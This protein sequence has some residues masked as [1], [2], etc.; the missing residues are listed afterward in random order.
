[1]IGADGSYRLPVPAGTY[2]V[3]AEW[4]GNLRSPRQVV[5]VADGQEVK[6]VNLALLQGQEVSGT[7]REG[8]RPM[9]AVPVAATA[10]DG[11]KTAT[12]TLPAGTYT[13]VLTNGV[14]TLSA[15]GVARQVTVADGPVDGAD[16][17]S[18]A[19]SGAKPAAGTIL[20]LAG[21][22]MSGYGG[23]GGPAL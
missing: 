20:T 18:T 7:V 12:Q 8:E 16:F 6:G 3:F 2:I 9:A 1:A 11:S 17:P 13:L 10:Q 14:Y 15:G 22:G 19:P 4:F 23:D 21:N 5:T